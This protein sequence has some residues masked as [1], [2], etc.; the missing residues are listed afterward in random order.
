MR[1]SRSV[2]GERGGEIPPRHSPCKGPEVKYAFI[3]RHRHLW[4]ICVQC[5]VLR[6]SVSGFHQHLAR[7]GRIAHRRH[8]SDAALLAHI[9]GVYAEH[10]GAYGWPRIWRELLKRSIRAVT[11][12]SG[13][14]HV[15]PGTNV[16]L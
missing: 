12:D 7:R 13:C 1:A 8:L 2:L 10:R 11:T 5:R 6:V 9:S 15:P 16:L 3:E 14:S 4:P